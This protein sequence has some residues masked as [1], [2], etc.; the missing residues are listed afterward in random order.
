MGKKIVISLGMK[1]LGIDNAVATAS[2]EVRAMRPA[3]EL[4]VN[5]A[6]K[7]HE[8]VIVTGADHQI[9][10]LLLTTED[11]H[12]MPA[13]PLDVC[14]AMAAGQVGYL[15][16]RSIKEVLNE[17]GE[18]ME[19]A[20]I[21]SQVV[22][23]R[24]D[25][26]FIDPF[27]PIGD[28]YT[29]EVAKYL[30]EDR[31]WALKEVYGEGFRRAVPS[32]LPEK[33]VEL[34]TI[35]RTSKDAIVI[36]CV[37]GGIP[38]FEKEGQFQ[39]AEAVIEKDYTAGLLAE[40]LEADILLMLTDVDQIALNFETMSHEPLD[41]LSY[42]LADILMDEGQFAPGTMLPKVQMACKLTKDRPDRR[43][44]VTSLVAAEM[45]IEG[46]AGTIVKFK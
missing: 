37:G 3:A 11:A 36:T 27:K 31:D 17:E 23:D 19:V 33:I 15:L 2:A 34:E 20:T 30:A 1:A 21:L 26:T 40:E 38:V 35:K 10:R 16:Q 42:G 24:D 46:E 44:I 9:G 8:L 39:G 18:D 25:L 41:E 29:P 13:M 22:V 32:P 12:A 4:I 7:G 6:K 14:V 45:A 43:A 5:L 28:I